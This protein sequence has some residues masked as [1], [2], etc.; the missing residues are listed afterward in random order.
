M[1]APANPYEFKFADFIR[2]LAETKEELVVIH[3]PEVIGDTYADSTAARIPPCRRTRSHPSRLV[4]TR[5]LKDMFVLAWLCV[6]TREVSRS[7]RSEVV[8]RRTGA[9]V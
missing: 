3:H 1:V 4:T 7:D 8:R 6:E 2:L 5:G 9:G